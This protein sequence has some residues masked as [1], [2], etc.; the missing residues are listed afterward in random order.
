LTTGFAV[1]QLA[2]GIVFVI[3]VLLFPSGLAGLI[4]R[5]WMLLWRARS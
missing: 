5:S 1:W 2:F 3:V 4:F